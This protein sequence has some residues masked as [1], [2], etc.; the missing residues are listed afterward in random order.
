[1]KKPGFRRSSKGSKP[2]AVGDE[3]LEAL[4]GRAPF[5]QAQVLYLMKTEF[6]RARRH[7]FALSCILVQVDRLQS[8]C[9]IHGVE[10]KGKLLAALAKLLGEVTRGH[11]HIGTATDDRFLLLMPHTAIDEAKVVAERI[12]ERFGDL[13]LSSGASVLPLSLSIGLVSSDEQEAMFFDTIVA[14]AEVALEWA[15]QDG[16]DRVSCFEKDRYLGPDGTTPVP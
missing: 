5:N 16:G 11:D 2:A 10:L 9:D 3:P 7:G 13:E 1:M 8:L 6:A 14:Q 4:A 15:I 12:R